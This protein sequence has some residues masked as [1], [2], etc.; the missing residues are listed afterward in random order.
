VDILLERAEDENLMTQPQL[1]NNL[2]FLVFA[3]HDTT[4]AFLSN[5]LYLLSK[6]PDVIEKLKEEQRHY[7][8]EFTVEI[9]AEMPLLNAVLKEALRLVPIADTVSRRVPED[10]IYKQWTLPKGYL[11]QPSI[12]TLHHGKLISEPSSY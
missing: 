1:F 12:V 9:L 5:V 8:D 10:T 4:S 11:L 3:A 6:H 7:G 2:L